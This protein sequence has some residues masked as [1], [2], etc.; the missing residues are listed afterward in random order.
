MSSILFTKIYDYE[1]YIENDDLYM[2]D[3]RTN[4]KVRAL[5]DGI[6]VKEYNEVG[7]KSYTNFILG[8]DN[9]LYTWGDNEYMQLGR[10]TNTFPFELVTSVDSIKLPDGIYIKSVNDVMLRGGCFFVLASD[11]LVYSWGHN[12]YGVL[13]RDF[14]NAD[15]AGTECPEGF[16]CHTLAE[17]IIF[18]DGI[19]IKSINDID[20]G[21]FYMN[22][23][24]ALASDGNLYSW[25]DNRFGQL[26]R[27]KSYCDVGSCIVDE[28]V[29]EELGEETPKGCS[30]P[31][32]FEL[33]D[34]A[35]INSI[36]DIYNDGYSYF[37]IADNGLL[38]T[39]GLNDY[40]QLARDISECDIIAE[41]D[42]YD[43]DK[44]DYL[45]GCSIPKAIIF[46]D[47]AK[48]KSAN[49][50]RCVDS[51]VFA[52]SDNGQLYTWGLNHYGQL[53]RDISE[54][55]VDDYYRKKVPICVTPKVVL[56]PDNA[57]IRSIKDIRHISKA[58]FV[59]TDNSLLYTW[60]DYIN[61][62][63]YYKPRE[64]I[65]QNNAILSSVDDIN[66]N[67][68]IVRKLP[69]EQFSYDSITLRTY[70][71]VSS[72]DIIYAFGDGLQKYVKYTDTTITPMQLKS[73]N[74]DKLSIEEAELLLE[75]MLAI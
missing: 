45:L 18:P 66:I 9:K 41:V 50:I 6:K 7:Q 51:S 70:L 74:N 11:G 26:G 43:K 63:L 30:K 27:D 53:A 31:Q 48:L 54:C 42:E 72:D 21:T 44:E 37:A 5:P 33:P 23:M 62:P 56:F 55:V 59:I 40:G 36:Q 34:N 61:K 12:I 15:F 64:I 47:N 25:G 20:K 32:I 60:G 75:K 4:I 3:T 14:T 2:L 8:S 1:Y 24:F 68:V 13:G 58:I 49:D 38:Y 22:S 35:K 46:P 67:S 39:W 69:Y 28:E 16:D 71:L 52:I 17:P 57:K 73:E 29:K 19:Y 65:F 10:N